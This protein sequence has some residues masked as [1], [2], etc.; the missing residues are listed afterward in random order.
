[1]K[2]GCRKLEGGSK[3]VG[4]VWRVAEGQCGRPWFTIGEDREG[5]F[6]TRANVYV[7]HVGNPLR[8]LVLAW[9]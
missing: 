8:S 6:I 7:A 4:I 3:K 9:H 1:M 5:G 2:G